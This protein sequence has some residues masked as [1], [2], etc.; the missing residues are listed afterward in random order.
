MNDEKIS[1]ICFLIL[2]ESTFHSILKLNIPSFDE[3]S[4]TIKKWSIP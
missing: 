2:G 1:M 4:F 3:V